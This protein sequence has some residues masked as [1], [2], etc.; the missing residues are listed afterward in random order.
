MTETMSAELRID[1]R[2][3][4]DGRE[5][6]AWQGPGSLACADEMTLRYDCFLGDLWFEVG[7]NRIRADWGW[8]TLLDAGLGLQ[9][10]REA[11]RT[12]DRSVFDFTESDAIVA[13]ER[14]G[15]TVTIS[16][17]FSPAILTVT[18]DS[19]TRAVDDLTARLSAEMALRHPAIGANLVFRAF[20]ESRPP[21]AG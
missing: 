1:Y 20:V 7:P 3:T 9:W 5:N 12:K 16:A 2:L 14:R 10:V 11:L 19:F 21:A 15:E 18:W 13:F 6:S 17:D 8:V 4:G